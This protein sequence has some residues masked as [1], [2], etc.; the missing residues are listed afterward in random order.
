MNESVDGSDG[1]GA[2]EMCVCNR[3]R[4][5]GV[6]PGN[7]RSE[8]RSKVTSAGVVVSGILCVLQK[9]CALCISCTIHMQGPSDLWEE[10]GAQKRMETQVKW[11]S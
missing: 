4:E 2:R 10:K 5:I 1:D 7:Y 11:K 3:Q 8:N 6:A 9:T